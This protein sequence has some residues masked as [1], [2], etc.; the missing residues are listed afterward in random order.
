MRY[1]DLYILSLYNSHNSVC[2][3]IPWAAGTLPVGL[4]SIVAAVYPTL[5]LFSLVVL[6]NMW[7]EDRRSIQQFVV[8]VSLSTFMAFLVSYFKE[9]IFKVLS[10]NVE[11]AK[12]SK[13][14]RVLVVNLFIATSTILFAWSMS[15]IL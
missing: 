8:L 13:L 3:K 6:L 5:L 11:G 10:L 15:Q 14:S 4:A 9:R 2:K 7:N 1:I 12:S